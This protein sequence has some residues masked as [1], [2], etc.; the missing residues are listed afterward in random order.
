MAMPASDSTCDSTSQPKDYMQALDEADPNNEFNRN[1]N[2]SLLGLK[3]LNSQTGH[4]L[5]FSE[6]L[7]LKMEKKEDDLVILDDTPTI[8]QK[9]GNDLDLLSMPKKF[10]INDSIRNSFKDIMTNVKNVKLKPQ[11]NSNDANSLGN[12]LAQTKSIGLES[13]N[14]CNIIKNSNSQNGMTEKHLGNNLFENL[15]DIQG[16]Q[17]TSDKVLNNSSVKTVDTNSNPDVIELDDSIEDELLKCNGDSQSQTKNCEDDLDKK[18]ED[19]LLQMEVDMDL[20][21]KGNTADLKEENKLLELD[22]EN[23]NHSVTSVKSNHSITSVKSNQSVKSNHSINSNH[24]MKS[25]HSVKSEASVKSIDSDKSVK[26]IHSVKSVNSDKS[27]KSNH[28]I[29][30]ETSVH[31]ISSVHNKKKDDISIQSDSSNH[32][33]NSDISE[34]SNTNHSLNSEISVKSNS[35]TKSDISIHNGKPEVY[36]SSSKLDI[37]NESS[38]HSIKSDSNDQSTCKVVEPESKCD[39]LTKVEND[40]TN[41]DVTKSVRSEK[42]TDSQDDTKEMDVLEPSEDSQDAKSMASSIS[43][44]K[45]EKMDID[46][47][48]EKD[49]ALSSAKN[50]SDSKDTSDNEQCSIKSESCDSDLKSNNKGS[51]KCKI[52]ENENDTKSDGSDRKRPAESEDSGSPEPKKSRLDEVIGKL[53]TQIGIPLDKVKAMEELS[54]TDASHLDSEVTESKSEETETS[55]DTD[56]DEE[57]DD[58]DVAEMKTPV[59]SPKKSRRVSRKELSML[60]KAKVMLYLR[61]YRDETIKDLHRKIDDLQSSNEMWKN[62]AR[63]LERKMLELTVLQQ[64][65]EKRKAKTAALRQISTKSIGVQVDENK[66]EKQPIASP[67][68]TMSK[69][70]AQQQ[71]QNQTTPNKSGTKTPPRSSAPVVCQSPQGTQVPVMIQSPPAVTRQLIPITSNLTRPTYSVTTQSQIKQALS[72]PPQKTQIL[73]SPTQKPPEPPIGQYPCNKTVKSLL[74]TSRQQ[75][76]IIVSNSTKAMLFPTSNNPKVGQVPQQFIMVTSTPSMP[77]KTNMVTAISNAARPSAKI[78]DL[79]DE[80]EKQIVS[81]VART[82]SI[83]SVVSSIQ[84]Q[85]NVRNLTPQQAMLPQ[86]NIIFNGPAGTRFVSP[87][88]QPLQLVFNSGAQQIRPGSLLTVVTTPTSAGVR[89]PVISQQPNVGPPQLRAAQLVPLASLPRGTLPG[90]TMVTG[91]QQYNMMRTVRPPPPLQSAPSNQNNQQK[92]QLPPNPSQLVHPPPTQKQSHPA[93]LPVQDPPAIKPGEKPLAPKPTLKISRVSQGIV[94]S[95]NMTY[96]AKNHAEIQSYQLFAY[97]E[98]AAPSTPSL[99]KKVGDVKALP[100]PMACT[101]TQFQE[102]NRYHFAVRPVD[103]HGRPG[104]FSEPS[105]IHLMPM[106]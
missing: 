64:K 67:T 52:E 74:D 75:Q 60:V 71:S 35:S 68:H 28:S 12:L 37:H 93:P 88:Q 51:E 94:L 33:H 97:Q 77:T 82:P 49:D 89:P 98:T 69:G 53:G 48:E 56:V 58:D 3:A 81:H 18:E 32:S 99:W 91:A 19:K 14:K 13:R 106:K 11:D 42:D 79:T 38:S 96:I 44:D 26:S 8:L 6:Y 103:T 95:W 41:D 86:Q 7:S 36:I 46:S 63:D 90:T 45:E 9:N 25:N 101:L 57:D 31:S 15:K 102:G 61:T 66:V 24:S 100:L 92:S 16:T 1:F 84:S 59:K 5:D 76:Q 72:L 47:D 62:K 78:I 39:K 87:N 55:S 4:D 22:N 83:P 70:I 34:P 104:P 21:S 23:S 65:H 43:D 80:E 73:L 20:D 54:D 85:G 40:L 2:Q 30:S 17:E 29:I 50:S 105:S 27:E 10:T